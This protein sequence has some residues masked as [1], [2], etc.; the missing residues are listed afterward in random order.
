MISPTEG[1]I[2]IAELRL[3]KAVSFEEK[4]SRRVFLERTYYLS[5]SFLCIY[6]NSI[7][8]RHNQS[9]IEIS[10]PRPLWIFWISV[11]PER[12]TASWSHRRNMSGWFTCMKVDLRRDAF[13]YQSQWFCKFPHA[14]SSKLYLE[15]LLNIR[16]DTFELPGFSAW[17]P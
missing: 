17:V 12:C 15:H 6:T 2:G 1:R 4:E 7:L 10:V 9:N 11:A 14:H 13:L 5:I 16:L 8:F 3:T